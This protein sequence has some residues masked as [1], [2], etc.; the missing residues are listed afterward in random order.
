M[1]HTCAMSDG[2]AP[3]QGEFG[4]PEEPAGPAGEPG[5][6]YPQHN[7]GGPAY[8]Y[9]SQ[10]GHS[11]GY[12]QGTPAPPPGPPAPSPGGG[13]AQQLITIGDIVVTGDRIITPAGDMPLKGASWTVTDMSRTEEKMPTVAVVLAVVFFVF[14]FLGLLF[15][16][17]KEKATTGYVQVTVNSGGR[18]HSTMIPVQSPMAVTE[19]M[20]QVNYARN[21]CA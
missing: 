1:G 18:F 6:G 13:H 10:G 5:Y 2:S 21:V 19:I 7:N 11:Y 9:P 17:M 12:P 14:C 3:G 8:G 15:L 4:P 20:H 16:L